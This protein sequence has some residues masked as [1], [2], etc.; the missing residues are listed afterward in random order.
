MHIWEV[1]L[2]FSLEECERARGREKERERENAGFLHQLHQLS[3]LMIVEDTRLC[4]LAWRNT[5]AKRT[6]LR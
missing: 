3:S 4:S 5:A 2:S 1:V 6:C